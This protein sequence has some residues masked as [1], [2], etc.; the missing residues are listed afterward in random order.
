MPA[1]L[2][3][4]AK[5]VRKGYTISNGQLR[6][7]MRNHS[8]DMMFFGSEMKTSFTAFAITIFAALPLFKKFVQGHLS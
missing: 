5:F 3:V 2:F 7:K 8:A 4:P 1:L 6:T